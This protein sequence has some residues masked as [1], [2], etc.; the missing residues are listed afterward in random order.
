MDWVLPVYP[1]SRQRF[2]GCSSQTAGREITIPSSVASKSLMSC[3]FAPERTT[4]SGS[5]FSSVKTL[6]FVPIFSTVGWVTSH[7]LPCQGCFDHT[8]INALPFPA[9]SLQLVIFFQAQ[10]PYLF[11]EACLLPFL[12]IS[13]NTAATPIF[14]WDRFPL[15]PRP[16]NIED[17]FQNLP[18]GQSG[19]S[20]SGGFLIM[21]ARIS[22]L[23]R[24]I[25]FYFFPQ[26]IRYGPGARTLF[27]L[28][29]LTPGHYITIPLI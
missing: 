6:R 12:K 19:P 26:L 11:K 29:F 24:N 27:L 25:L 15:A 22:L 9:N 4:D 1:A 7:R 10:Y 16:Q 17:A 21:F 23:F 20:L 14:P 8:A 2:C 28:H 5:P 18:G 3:V 13:V